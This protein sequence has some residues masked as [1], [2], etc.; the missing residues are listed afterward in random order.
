M[1]SLRSILL[2]NKIFQQLVR[3]NGRA[4]SKIKII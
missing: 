4:I 1:E 3:R 2:I